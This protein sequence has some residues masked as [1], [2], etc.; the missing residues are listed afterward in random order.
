MLIHY[1]HMHI[2][3]IHKLKHTYNIYITLVPV[4]ATH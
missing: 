2:L 1:V 3:Y 4:Y